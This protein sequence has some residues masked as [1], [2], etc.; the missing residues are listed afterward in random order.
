MS[1][2]LFDPLRALRVLNRHQVRYVLIGG[3][4]AE[5][6]GAPLATNDLDICY[7]RPRDNL[8]RLAAALHELEA[9]LRVARVDE[10]LP[11]LL[12]A[13]TLAAGDSFM[14]RTAAGDLDVLATPSGTSGYRDLAAKAIVFDL[15]RGLLVPVVDLGDLIRMKEASARPKD[16]AHLA[17]LTALQEIVEEQA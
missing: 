16:A 2:A 9:E 6:L 10:K 15:G 13:Q 5:L 12:D 4:A 7:D 14:F 17:T 8:E 3:F 11:F 1:R